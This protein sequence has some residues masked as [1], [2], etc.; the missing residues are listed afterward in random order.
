MA[1]PVIVCHAEDCP[2]R[3]NPKKPLRV[4]DETAHAWIFACP[5]CLN[6]RAIAKQKIGGTIG[7]GRRDDQPAKQYW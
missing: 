7:A 5:T 6:V 4:T 2:A 3:K 1:R